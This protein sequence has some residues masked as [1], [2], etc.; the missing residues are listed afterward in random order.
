MV[1]LPGESIVEKLHCIGPGND[2]LDVVL[3]AQATKTKI[4]K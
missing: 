4:D 3:K 1:T 2:I